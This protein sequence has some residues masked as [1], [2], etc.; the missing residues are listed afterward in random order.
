VPAGRGR[1]ADLIS[2]QSSRFTIC[3]C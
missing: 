1:H 2:A 3:I